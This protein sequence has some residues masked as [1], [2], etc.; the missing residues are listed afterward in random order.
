VTRRMV[1]AVR[2]LRRVKG[3]YE[4]KVEYMPG[5]VKTF[6]GKD[7]AWIFAEIENALD[8]QVKTLSGVVEVQEN[9]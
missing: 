2:P 5:Y 7:L 1:M 3:A 6:V 8:N 4:G 9:D